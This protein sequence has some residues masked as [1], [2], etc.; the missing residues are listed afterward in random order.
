VTGSGAKVGDWL[1]ADDRIDMVTLTGS[2]KVGM[3]IAR[4]SADYLHRI[5]LELG[6]NDPFIILGDADLEKA[7]G[8]ALVTRLV[9]A[10]QRCCAGK[11]FIVDNSIKKPSQM[12]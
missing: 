3:E 6:G 11:R 8:E 10:G 12:R 9:N 1:I 4:N 2:T 7:V 5:H